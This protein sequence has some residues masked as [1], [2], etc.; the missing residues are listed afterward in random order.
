LE[1]GWISTD[2]PDKKEKAEGAGKGEEAMDIDD[3]DKEQ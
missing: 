3:M 1:D 2:N